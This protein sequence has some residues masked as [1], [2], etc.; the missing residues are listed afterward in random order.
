MS[1]AEDRRY[2]DRRISEWLIEVDRR[3]NA[4]RRFTDELPAEESPEA[5]AYAARTD[6]EN[7]PY[8]PCAWADVPGWPDR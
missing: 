8:H 4:G 1:A 2:F 6:P 5:L 7:R 3:H